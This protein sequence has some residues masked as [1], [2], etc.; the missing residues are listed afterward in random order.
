[1]RLDSFTE[2]TQPKSCNVRCSCACPLLL[3]LKLYH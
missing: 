2:K 1:V 3:P